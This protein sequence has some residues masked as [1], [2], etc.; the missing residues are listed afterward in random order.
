M[1]E[2]GFGNGE[3]LVEQ[4][5]RN[6]GLNFLGIEVHLPGVGHCLLHIESEGV[7]N[8]RLISQDAIDVLQHR[9]PDSALAR[10]NLY[11]PDPWP[12]KRHHKRRLI[13]VGFLELIARKLGPHGE[14]FIATDWANYAQ[15]I[16]DIIGP[17]NTFRLV[18]RREHAGDSPIDRPSTK[19]ERRG[20]GKGHRIWDWQLRKKS[21]R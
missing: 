9:L 3:S 18:N 5:K 2:I 20:L 21:A 4:A 13:Q 6:P 11:F 8:V 12:K 16:D 10:L 15:H 17:S 1:L 19:F 7:S 14:F